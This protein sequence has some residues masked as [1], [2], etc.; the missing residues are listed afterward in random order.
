MSDEDLGQRQKV[1]E[2]LKFTKSFDLYGED[3]Q[4]W[5]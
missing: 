5:N 4:V 2:K 1:C 3:T